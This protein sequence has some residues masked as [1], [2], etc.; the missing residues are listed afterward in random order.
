MYYQYYVFL[1]I[2][3]DKGLTAKEETEESLLRRPLS[4]KEPDLPAQV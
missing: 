1:F 4:P 2:R 3:Y